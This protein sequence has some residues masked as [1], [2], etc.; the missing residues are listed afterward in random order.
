MVADTYMHDHSHSHD[1]RTTIKKRKRISDQHLPPT[2]QARQH[3]R[4]ISLDNRTFSINT[5]PSLDIVRPADLPSRCYDWVVQ[6]VGVHY[7]RNQSWFM[8]DYRPVNV[9]LS[10]GMWCQGVGSVRIDVQKL[11]YAGVGMP[12]VSLVLRDVLHIPK[13]VCNGVSLALLSHLEGCDGGLGDRISGERLVLRSF[14]GLTKFALLGDPMGE[15]ILEELMEDDLPGNLLSLH[16]QLSD[17]DVAS[18]K[19]L[20]V[21][22]HS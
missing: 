20:V 17:A 7:A 4:K 15:S 13:A 19:G 6:K 14:R 12:F 5:R 16:L 8:D 9:A 22:S 21:V 11:D 2:S 10:G 1:V 3:N 18:I